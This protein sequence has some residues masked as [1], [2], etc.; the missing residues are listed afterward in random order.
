MRECLLKEF[1]AQSSK[2]KVKIIPHSAFRIPQSKSAILL[3][4]LGALTGFFTSGL[5]HYNLGDQ[6]VAMVFFILM[7]LSE[8]KMQSAKCKMKEEI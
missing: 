6:E 2:F 4:S 3:G 5:V 1:K 7:G 8:R